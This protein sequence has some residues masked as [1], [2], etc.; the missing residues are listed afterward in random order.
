MMSRRYT[1]YSQTKYRK[2]LSVANS[3]KICKI[4]YNHFGLKIWIA[5]RWCV[6]CSKNINTISQR[7]K[8]LNYDLLTISK[9]NLKMKNN[10]PALVLIGWTHFVYVINN[11]HEDGGRGMA[12]FTWRRARSAHTGGRGVGSCL[13]YIYRC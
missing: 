11:A 10:I 5:S 4:M 9:K 2:K 8:N 3:R 1:C 12:A 7:H 13:P 6:T